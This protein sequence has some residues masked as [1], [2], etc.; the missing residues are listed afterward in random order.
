LKG[1]GGAGFFFCQQKNLE[2]GYQTREKEI[3]RTKPFP[4]FNVRP[5]KAA[6]GKTSATEEARLLRL[7]R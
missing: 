2:R 6:F 4:S 1:K 3:T 5:K 7:S